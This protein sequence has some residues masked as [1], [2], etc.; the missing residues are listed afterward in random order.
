MSWWNASNFTDLAS[1]ALKTAQKKIDSALDINEDGTEKHATSM[2][3]WIC[4]LSAD[5]YFILISRCELS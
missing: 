4:I 3:L 1:K 2:Y 5:L